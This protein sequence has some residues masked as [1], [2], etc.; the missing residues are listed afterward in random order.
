MRDSQYATEIATAIKS[1]GEGENEAR[2]ERL[3]VKEQKQVEI[4]FS[5]WKK[6]NIVLRPLDLPESDLLQLMENGFGKVLSDKFLADLR[7]SIDNFLTK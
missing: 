6:G 2:I 5:W 4:R 1:Y 7:S 3:F